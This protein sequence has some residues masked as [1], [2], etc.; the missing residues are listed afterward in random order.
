[1]AG[2]TAT[3]ALLRRRSWLW[4]SAPHIARVVPKLE[5][6]TVTRQLD[7]QSAQLRKLA[8]RPTMVRKAFA[9]AVA[10]WLIDAAALW[11]F[12]AA[13]DVTMNPVFVLA[14]F[15][16]AN[17]AAAVPITPGG[18]GLVEVTLAVTLTSFGAPPSAT[19]LGIAAYRVFNYWLPIPASILTYLVVRRIKTPPTPLGPGIPSDPLD[20]TNVLL[21]DGSLGD[22]HRVCHANTRTLSTTSYSTSEKQAIQSCT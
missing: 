10:N 11:V 4:T 16:L 17:L 3:D 5:P 21:S 22:P 9:W 6:G 13:F 15:A 20:T 18:L 1:L 14:A 7:D 8:S 2:A 12:L 19:A